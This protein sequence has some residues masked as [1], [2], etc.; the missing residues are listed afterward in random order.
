MLE[1][2][3]GRKKNWFFFRKEKKQNT[4]TKKTNCADWL[5]ERENLIM[6]AF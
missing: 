2:V 4:H 1:G 5:S 6:A 3:G